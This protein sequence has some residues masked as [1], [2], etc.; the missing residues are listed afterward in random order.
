MFNFWTVLTIFELCD[1]M[2][3]DY[4]FHYFLNK[5]GGVMEKA[6]LDLKRIDFPVI[7]APIALIIIFCLFSFITPEGTTSFLAGLKPF[8]GDTM[9]LFYL[10]IN[11]AVFILAFYLAFSKYG[12]IVLGT[13]GEKPATSFWGW[14]A[15][16]F[17]CGMAGDV[18]YYG[19]TEWVLYSQEPYIQSLG[20]VYDYSVSYSLFFW[21]NF[22]L[23][24]VLAVAFGF[25]IHV[26]KRNKQKYSESLRPLLGK[27]TDGI[28]GKIIDIFVLFITICAVTCSLCFTVPIMTACINKLFGIPDSKYITIAFM[29]IICVT[30]TISVSRGLKG[31]EFLSKICIYVFLALIAYILFLGG[32]TRYI[33][34]SAFQQTGVT[35]THM[36]DM[37]TFTDPS[38]EYSFVQDYCAFYDAYWITWAITVPY[39]ISIISKG[40]TIK[41]V[42]LGGFLFAIPGS[43]LSFLVIPNF[44]IAKQVSGAFDF[45]G[46]YLGTGNMYEV[47][48][49]TLSQLPLKE[50]ALI[51]MMISM[52]CFT[53]TSLDSMSLTCSYYSYKSITNE[54]LP[55]KKVRVT[56]AILLILLPLFITFAEFSYSNIQDIAVIA[57]FFGGIIII[58]VLCAFFKDANKYFENK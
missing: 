15:M 4:D 35:L 3:K 18:L 40:R 45:I 53:A 24:L 55:H 28:L 56:W 47:V 6:K 14:G 7:I 58:L 43:I 52:I 22:W 21:S 12:K 54:E 13:P 36:I 16:M 8:F 38:R 44:A 49:A 50:I 37:F 20:N 31:I 33:L 27:S 41:E 10:F 39:F 19:Y 57:G 1:N 2:F 17:C 11:F 9:S 51:I 23:Y 46:L 30:Y 42:I 25:M 32:E 48:V 26:R 34:E 29:L 5:R